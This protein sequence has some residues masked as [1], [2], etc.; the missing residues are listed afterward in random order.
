MSISLN[1]QLDPKTDYRYLDLSEASRQ[2]PRNG[3]R[4]RV[5]LVAFNVTDYYSLPVR[6]LSLT[7]SM[8]EETAGKADVRYLESE[9]DRDWMPLIERVVAWE[10]SIIGFSTN[11]WNLR[12]VLQFIEAIK[13]R[14]PGI[15][16]LLGGQEVTNSVTDFHQ[17][18]SGIDYIVEGEGEFPLLQFLANWLPEERRL[19]DPAAVSGLRYRSNG[20]TVLTRPADLVASL[21]DLPSPILA[22]LLPAKAR[23]KLG[24]MLEGAR[25]CPNLC[26]FCFEGSRRHKVRM[27]STDRLSAEAKYMAERGATYFHLL[28]P[29]LCNS[30]P[31]RLKAM[32]DLFKELNQKHKMLISLETYAQHITDAIAPYLSEFTSVDIG[33]QSINPETHREIRRQFDPDRF[34]AGLESLRKANRRFNLYLICGLPYETA[35]T[36]LEGIRFVLDRKPVQVFFNELCLLNGTELR[37]RSVEYGYD[38]E[39]D[40][41]Y[42]VHASKWMDHRDLR[43]VNVLSKVIERRHNLSLDCLFPL[44]PWTKHAASAHRTVRVPHQ[45][46]C[47]HSCPGCLAGSPDFGAAASRPGNL[48]EA[49]AG[50]DVEIFGNHDITGPAYLKLYGELMLMG[51]SRIKLLAPLESFPSSDLAQKLLSFG[52]L[53]YTT[54]YAGAAPSSRSADRSPQAHHA[55]GNLGNLCRTFN[56]FGSASPKPFVEVVVL[57]SPGESPQDYVDKI[58]LVSQYAPD[59]ITVP[60]ALG[61]REEEWTSALISCFREQLQQERWIKLPI[62]MADRSLAEHPDREQLL[63]LL[64]GFGLLSREPDSPP[65]AAACCGPTPA[66][67]G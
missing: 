10:P 11:I 25:G 24:I 42:R 52:L 66:D 61:D 23:Y 38:F 53:H 32:D 17:Q 63:T 56:L 2:W 33:L 3:S 41:P 39:S 40:P 50:A 35:V 22:G 18:N 64:D 9:I 30:N 5:L 7:S 13:R 57:H 26:T 59:L 54:C 4:T 28:D 20:A 31:L 65:C 36:F 45:A 19:S 8:H 34:L 37:R 47:T 43:M 1:N 29:I 51:A 46:W 67:I 60:Q 6:I 15:T 55:L 44:A 48:H 21:D 12:T 62:V 27:A 16:T 49:I 14:A 58:K